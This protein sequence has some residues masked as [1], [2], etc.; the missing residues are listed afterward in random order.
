MHIILE[1]VFWFCT[2][3]NVLLTYKMW[4]SINVTGKNDME[5]CDEIDLNVF[6]IQSRCNNV[7]AMMQI[8]I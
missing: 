5:I 2:L 6:D 4:F 3:Y 1:K 7:D 8:A